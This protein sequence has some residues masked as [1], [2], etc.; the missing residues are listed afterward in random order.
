MK[1]TSIA[2]S[3]AKIQ[4]QLTCKIAVIFSIANAYRG[5]SESVIN[6]INLGYN[7][8]PNSAKAQKGKMNNRKNNILSLIVLECLHSSARTKSIMKDMVV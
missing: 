7:T 5:I 3:D 8:L 1:M 4:R 2:N 6:K